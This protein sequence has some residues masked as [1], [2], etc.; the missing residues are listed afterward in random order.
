MEGDVEKKS[1]SR[2]SR[3]R[4]MRYVLPSVRTRPFGPR[5]FIPVSL[6][7]QRW[8]AS[9]LLLRQ[10]QTFTPSFFRL[11]LHFVQNFFRF[12]YISFFLILFSSPFWTLFSLF[13]PLHFLFLL[14]Q[15]QPILSFLFFS[16][17]IPFRNFPSLLL[18]SFF[19]IF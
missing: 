5:P 13:P 12:N 3:G 11:M 17:P 8:I 7:L 10:T 6:P 16:S 19:F 14:R 1:F 9:Y 4:T 2:K 18:F 15:S